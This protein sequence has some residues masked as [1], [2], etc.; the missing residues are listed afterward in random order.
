MPGF[1]LRVNGTPL[2]PTTSTAVQMTF[3]YPAGLPCGS[4]VSVQNPDGLAATSALNPTPNVTG[5]LLGTGPVAGNAIFVVQG[6]GFSLG[7][8][9]TIGGAAAIVLSAAATAVTVRTPQG[10]PGQAQVVLTTV[11]GCSAV[12]TYTYQ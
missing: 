5:T 1:T 8:V 10:V 4:Q 7:T 6:N 3:P 11:G 2:A 9:V 12:T